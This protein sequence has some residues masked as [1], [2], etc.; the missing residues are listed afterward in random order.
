MNN[1]N[2]YRILRLLQIRENT[3]KLSSWQ[4]HASYQDGSREE[5]G[6]VSVR[7]WSRDRQLRGGVVVKD[8]KGPHKHNVVLGLLI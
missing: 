5:E 6:G 2:K 8:F 7:V 4:K 3:T 1:K